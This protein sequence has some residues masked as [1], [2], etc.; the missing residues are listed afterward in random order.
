MTGIKWVLLVLVLTF[1]SPARGDIQVSCVFME[2]CILPCSFQSGDD[3]VIHWIQMTTK[4]I[5]AHSYY[6]NQDQFGLQDQ[7]FRGRTSLFKDQISR[8]N[9]SLRLTGVEVPDQGRYKCYTSTITGNKDLFINLNVDA[10]VD[11]VDIQQVEN[12]ITCS[13]EG[14]Y[15]QPDLTWSTS[16]PSDVSLENNPTVQQTEQLLYNINSSLIASVTDLDYS[17][18]VSTRTNKRTATLF[19]LTSISGL[20]TE[21]TI[22]CETLNPPLTGLVWRFNHSQIIL[23]Q[24]GANVPY[25]VSEEWRQQV[26]SVS[27]SG[28]LTLKDFSSDQEGIYTCE[29]S[30]AEETY[31]T[32]TLLRIEKSQGDSTNVGAIIGGVFAVLVVVVVGLV[33]YCENKKDFSGQD[34]QIRRK[35][36]TN[37][38]KVENGA[39]TTTMSNPLLNKDQQ[40]E[41]VE[42]KE[43]QGED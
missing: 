32:T 40:Q 18:T 10:P 5:Q 34:N 7:R 25:T 9:A 1:L 29:L 31:V 19:K 43:Q 39:K 6:H 27:E 14:I 35:D 17:C 16:P 41:Q 28:S 23:N 20:D 12:R 21:T 36:G 33:L 3:V 15:P 8:G 22:P 37:V 2:S 13:S 26:K 42:Q 11:K 4:D 38:V 24:T 30:N